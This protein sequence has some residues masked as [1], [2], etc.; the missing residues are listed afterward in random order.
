MSTVVDVCLFLLL[1]S[2]AVVAF[3][4]PPA[5]D[6]QPPDAEAEAQALATS[7]TDV[8]V[9]RT[10]GETTHHRGT[11]AALVADAT[12]ANLTGPGGRGDPAPT[13][14]TETAVENATRRPNAQVAVTAKWQPYPGAPLTGCFSAG[15]RPPEGTQARTATLAVPS[16]LPQARTT[17]LDAAARDGYAGVATVIAE[18]I[19]QGSVTPE[20]Q[21][22][23]RRT[24]PAAKATRRRA[25]RLAS[26]LGVNIEDALESGDS[27]AVRRVLRETLKAQLEADLRDSF[28]TPHAAAEAVSVSTVR[29]TVTVWAA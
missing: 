23:P 22:E 18:T 25:Q 24:D 2:G 8:L 26:A 15:N 28:E 5:T 17:A 9:P 13:Q 1:L 11:Y 3:M 21:L 7:T 29:L 10:A 20:S 19:V 6:G 4:V 27:D 12:V 16:E 14:A